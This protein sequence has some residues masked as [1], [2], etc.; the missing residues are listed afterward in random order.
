MVHIISRNTKI[1]K[2]ANISLPPIISCGSN[3][4]YCKNKC[5]AV[6]LYRFRSEVKK[7]WDENFE[8]LKEDREY[9]F[10][11][12][13]RYL[14]HHHSKYFRWHVSGDIV[15]QDYYEKMKQIAEDYDE[16]YYLVYT[17]RY[18]LN[19]SFP[20]KNLAV[21]L[22]TWPKIPLPT[23]NFPLA[24]LPEDVRAYDYIRCQGHCE[25]C[26]ICWHKKVNILLQKH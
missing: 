7:A 15:D 18:D 8:I 1:G 25:N 3:A 26:R 21:I 5:Y 17:K 11:S 20:P 4:I 13:R 6:N 24:F 19:L 16:T 22:S 14:L 12:I 9:Y 23:S 2:T 10:N